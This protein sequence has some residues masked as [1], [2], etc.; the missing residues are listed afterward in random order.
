MATSVL[1]AKMNVSTRW[2]GEN[3]SEP[4]NCLGPNRK[5]AITEVLVA[6][7]VWLSEGDIYD[8]EATELTLMDI[9]RLISMAEVGIAKGAVPMTEERRVT[10]DKTSKLLREAIR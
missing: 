5:A 6:K 8:A 7:R 10:I 4:D 2:I 9:S 1:S 3:M